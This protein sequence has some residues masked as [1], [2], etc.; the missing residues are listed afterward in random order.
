[1]NP[2]SVLK[3]TED[4]D[5]LKRTEQESAPNEIDVDS[6]N[7]SIP[8][9]RIVDRLDLQL[10]VAIIV[11]FVSAWLFL[12]NRICNFTDSEPINVQMSYIF[13]HY[14]LSLVLLLCIYITAVKGSYVLRQDNDDLKGANYQVVK[15]FI[16]GW[17]PALLICLGVLAFSGFIPWYMGAILSIGLLYWALQKLG[18]S[19]VFRAIILLA[20]VILFPVFISTMTVTMKDINVVLDKDYYSLTDD[21]V[22][23]AETKGYACNHSLV[24]LGQDELYPDTKYYVGKRNIIV[25]ASCIRDN[26]ISVGTLSPASGLQNFLTYPYK[27]MFG[28]STVTDSSNQSRPYYKSKSVIINNVAL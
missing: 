20:I 26:I 15:L 23:S 7:T 28:L 22:I 17:F 2:F 21:I 8:S 24:S 9:K 27:K 6:K 18:I 12:N 11:F 25:P 5:T 13:V 1:M 3:P 10:L 4:I 16:E 14:V 19:P